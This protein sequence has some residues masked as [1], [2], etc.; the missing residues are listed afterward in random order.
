MQAK[1]FPKLLLALPLVLM[2][3]LGGL[4][5][6]GLSIDLNTVPSPVMGKPMPAFDS[7]ALRESDGRLSAQDLR[8]PALINVWASWCIA[9]REENPRLLAL[10][11]EGVRIYGIDYLDRMPEARAWLEREGDPFEAVVFDGD[12][13]L[14]A[15]LGVVAAPET[16]VVDAQGMVRYRHIG[17]INQTVMDE[18]REALSSKPRKPLTGS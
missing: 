10:K 12:G 7:L 15:A 3:I 11:E 18:L 6:R 9:C 14:G 13:K 5:W 4:Y 16:Y 8:F 17:A 1:P 2:T